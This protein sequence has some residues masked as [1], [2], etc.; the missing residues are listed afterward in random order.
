MSDSKVLAGANVGSMSYDGPDALI[1]D[2]SAL[3]D[4]A[5]NHVAREYNSAQALLCWSIGK[6]IDEE[7][8]KSER[9]EYGEA[10]VAS[11]SNHLALSY[12][13]GYSRPNLFRMIKLA[14]SF[15]PI[16]KLSQH[17]RDNC[18]GLILF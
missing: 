1:K 15:P 7:I 4:K 17:C 11:L 6:R 8:L 3:I 13:K 12:G 2:I 16:M 5:K 9:A 14:K 10:I 18:L